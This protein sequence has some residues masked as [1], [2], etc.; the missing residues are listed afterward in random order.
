MHTT[1]KLLPVIILFFISCSHP[2]S[3][4]DELIAKKD[5]LRNIQLNITKELNNIDVALASYDTTLNSE[6]DEEIIKQII[7]KK[8]KIAV[9]EKDIKELE[10]K[11]SSNKV[12]DDNIA[13]AVK[14]MKYEPFNHYF[15][16]FGNAEA[17]KYANLSP[18]MGGKV[19]K[20]YVVEGQ[21]VK[22]GAL[23]LRLNTEAIERQIEGVK[24][25]LDFATKTYNKQKALWE[26][27]IGSEIQY[28][29]AKSAKEAL[30]AQLE[31]L[32]AQMD[33]A[34]LRAPFNGIVNRIYPK[35]GEMAS[36]QMP[37]IEFVNLKKINIK[38]KVSEKYINAVKAGQ[39]VHVS[40][41]SIPGFGKEVKIVRASKVI[42]P[43]SRTFDIELKIDNADEMIKP[44]M[45]T[46]IRINDFSEKNALTVPSLVIKKDISGDY[47]YVIKK[48]DNAFIADKRPITSGLSYQDSTMVVKGLTPGDQVIVE[49]Y[50][51]VS[52]GIKV[53]VKQKY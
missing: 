35:V 40:F 42:N 39:Y 25:N 27:K 6:N 15:I 29:Q 36:P 51:M 9:I 47:V 8:N 38:A 20:I 24:S 48:K 2:K 46:T 26:Q 17:D 33:M 53:S 16:V 22:K 10:D 13:V 18:E 7:A 4:Y 37:V 31:A 49:G 3:T 45:I 44:N 32:E 52:S 50:N 23:L 30:E 21:K 14:T 12:E 19:E 5:S 41:S 43:K 1:V 11:L 34:Y 28:L